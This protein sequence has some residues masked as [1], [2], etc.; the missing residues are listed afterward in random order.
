LYI[1]PVSHL[2]EPAFARALTP[3]AG[4]GGTLFD[5]WSYLD[6]KVPVMLAEPSD[7]GRWA[8]DGEGFIDGVY[9][10]RCAGCGRDAYDSADCPRCHRP[11]GLAE[12][13]AAESR[14]AVPR[15]CPGCNELE[16]TLIGFAPG[17]V[18][19][20]GAGR[21]PAPKPL[22]ALG[23]PG[24]QVVAIACDNCDWATVS[25]RCPIC[26]AAPPLRPRPH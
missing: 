21:P 3:C 23:E 18:R 15:R 26:D 9:R 5:L 6:R 11:G 25:E 4:C 17:T 2:D 13:L 19:V 10:I 16:L 12:G 22:A 24:F 7:D 14:L 1:A 8:F 20:K